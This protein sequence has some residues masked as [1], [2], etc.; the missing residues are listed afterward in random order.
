M[1]LAIIT[2]LLHFRKKESPWFLYI[3]L[4]LFIASSLVNF[5]GNLIYPTFVDILFVYI[6]FL[7]IWRRS[8]VYHRLK[9]ERRKNSVNSEDSLSTTSASELQAQQHQVH[10]GKGERIEYGGNTVLSMDSMGLS[11]IGGGG[12]HHLHHESAIDLEPIDFEYFVDEPMGS[13]N[14]FRVDFGESPLN[15]RGR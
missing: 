2:C 7:I 10:R 9:E 11:S 1:G 12:I 3:S 8:V 13:E 6:F 15:S 14:M 5:S 4:T